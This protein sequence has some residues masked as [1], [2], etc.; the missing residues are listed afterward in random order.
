MFLINIIS[1]IE[2][3][4]Q[5]KNV[6]VIVR[7]VHLLVSTEVISQWTFLKSEWYDVKSNNIHK[8]DPSKPLSKLRYLRK[9]ISDVS[10]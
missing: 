7:G 1:R 3:K 2:A 5:V 8:I 9:S 10:F 4:N 6:I